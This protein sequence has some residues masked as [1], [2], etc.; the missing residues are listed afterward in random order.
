MSSSLIQLCIIIILLKD[1]NNTTLLMAC[2]VE[3]VQG[4]ACLL[5]TVLTTDPRVMRF[6]LGNCDCNNPRTHIATHPHCDQDTLGTS[7]NNIRSLIN[8]SLPVS[9]N[10]VCLSTSLSM[11]PD[12]PIHAPVA[13]LI[14][15]MAS[16]LLNLGFVIYCIVAT[17]QAFK[18]MRTVDRITTHKCIV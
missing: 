5:T 11:V 13:I 2:V 10:F 18:F 4:I 14:F 16:V 12:S 7:K 3:A 6:P 1:K 9:I 8:F 17:V 15:L